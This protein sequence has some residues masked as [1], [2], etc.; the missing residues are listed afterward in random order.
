MLSPLS[1]DPENEIFPQLTY[2]TLKTTGIWLSGNCSFALGL[3]FNS[4]PAVHFHLAI[5]ELWDWSS[6]QDKQFM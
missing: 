6:T 1:I 3:L 5:L 2:T 4:R